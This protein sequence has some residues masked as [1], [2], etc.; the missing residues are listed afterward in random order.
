[1]ADPIQYVYAVVDNDPRYAATPPGI[2]ELP[3]RVEG[4]G[5]IAALMTEVDGSTYAADEVEARTADIQWLGPRARAHDSVVTWAG[6]Q[7]AVVPLP[8][9]SLFRDAASVRAMLRTRQNDLVRML[10]HVRD[11]QEFIVRL[12]RIDHELSSQLAALSPRVA[13]LER[14]AA[15]ASPGQR[16]L[17]QR[18]LESERAAELSRVSSDTAQSVY[19]A[20]VKH[21]TDS[22]I[23]PIPR[24]PREG[25]AGPAVLNAS[26]LLP[27]E[28]TDP[29]RRELTGLIA[30]HE[31]RG[32]RFEFTGPWPPYHFVRDRE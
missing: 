3:V 15:A 8:M 6:D 9:F 5:E 2:D 1:M 23:E 27:R 29:F 4:E 30:E 25:S 12:F 13:E 16:Y 21:A 28:D 24:H 19:D 20:L 22:T 32:F 31:P 11:H 17:L 26:F 7:G 10:A 18:K 14:T